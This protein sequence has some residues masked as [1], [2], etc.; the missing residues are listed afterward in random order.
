MKSNTFF[1]LLV[2]IGLSA[3]F[4][5]CEKEDTPV[6]MESGE[7]GALAWKLTNDGTLT[8]SGNGEM[9]NYSY[10]S[11]LVYDLNSPPWLYGSIA[12]KSVVIG[13]GVT[14]I[15][16]HAF[17]N[18]SK[19][20]SITIPKSVTSIFFGDFMGFFP[21]K[22][23]TGIASIQV[24]GANPVYSSKDGVLFDKAMTTLLQYPEKK[25]GAYTIP[26]SVT[27]IGGGA[28]WGCEDLTSVT[29]GNGVTNIGDSAFR[30]CGNLTS[31]DIGDGVTSMGFSAFDYCDGLSS[32][33][34]RALEPPTVGIWGFMK[35]DKTICILFVPG[36]SIE[37][38]RKAYEWSDFA[39]I[40]AIDDAR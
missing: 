9:P 32:I 16:S 33:T 17:Y 29:I 36:E 8:I 12:I 5:S 35:V 27:S 40:Q 22:G 38:Y 14:S 2:A 20:I 39:Q 31:V 28:F 24:D 34:C 15:G 7:T 26:E 1:A 21:F 30:G 37:K 3:L 25:P 10:V 19:L 13:N 6:V 23:N 4:P 11:T 18:C